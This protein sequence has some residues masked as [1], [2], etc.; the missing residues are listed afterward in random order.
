MAD[1]KYREGVSDRYYQAFHGKDDKGE[2][3]G[4]FGK[5]DRDRY[6]AY[7]TATKGL[8]EE[9]A[10]EALEGGM[11]FG[12]SDR[13]RYDALMAKRGEAKEKAETVVEKEEVTPK[14]EE[15]VEKA[16][17][18]KDQKT[19]QVQQVQQIQQPATTTPSGGD[20]SDFGGQNRT[21]G[22]NQNTI[23]DNNEIFGNVNQGNQDF[24]VNIA[25][26]G[27]KSDGGMSN[28]AYGAAA[29]AS[30][31]NSYNRDRATFNAGGE[32]A[33]YARQADAVT[34]A[35][36]R[37]K[38]LDTTTDMNI[39]YFRKASDRATLGLY[40]DVWNMKA[41]TWKAP[42]ELDPIEVTYNKDTEEEKK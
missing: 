6:D 23:G 2:L 37:I 42:G 11:Q 41:P 31:E 19:Q 40:G 28:M 20:S 34:G 32:A 18:F 26:G 38:A 4:S 22:N 33:K 17:D 29:K 16:Q 21:F 14:T 5:H 3:T 8:D 12:D 30:M 27:N 13:A 7:K 15:S 10:F 35:S 39:D 25:G 24:S 1:P 9:V 36:N